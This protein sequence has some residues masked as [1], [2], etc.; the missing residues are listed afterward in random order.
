MQSSSPSSFPPAKN[1]KANAS[2]PNYKARTKKLTKRK[3]SSSSNASSRRLNQALVAC[4]DAPSVFSILQ[5]TSGALTLPAGGGALNTVNFSTALHRLARHSVFFST[6]QDWQQQQQAVRAS[7]LSDPRF[8]LFLASLAE[9]LAVSFEASLD[10]NDSNTK[11]ATKPPLPATKLNLNFKSRELSN[12][13]W[14]L[15]KL[16]IVPPVKAMAIQLDS[17]NNVSNGEETAVV[18]LRENAKRVRASVMEVA[19]QRH[20]GND[21]E[22]SSSSAQLWIPALSQ[23]AGHIM[24]TI[25]NIIA[26]EY[27][28]DNGS[29]SDDSRGERKNQKFSPYQFQQQEWSNLLWA[30]GTS[31]RAAPEVFAIIATQ[32]IQK[33]K[34]LILQAEKERQTSNNNNNLGQILRPQEWSNSIYAFARVQV[35]QGHEELMSYIAHLLDHYPEF[36]KAYKTQELSNTAWGVATLL[37]N[38]KGKAGNSAVITPTETSTAL[39]ILRQM[40][41]ELVERAAEFKPQELANTIW[42]LATTGFGISSSSLPAS[43]VAAGNNNNY[44]ILSSDQPVQDNEL[45]LQVIDACATAALPRLA[46]FKSQELNNMAWA[47]ARLFSDDRNDVCNTDPAVQQLLYGIGRQLCHPKR[48]VAAQDIGTALWS[49]ATVGFPDYDVYR[50]VAS[51]LSREFRIAKFY[52]PQELSNTVWS[53]ATVEMPLTDDQKN[54]FDTTIVPEKEQSTNYQVRVDKDPVLA[55]LDIAA[56]ELMRR[57]YEFKA[58]EIKDVLW[59]FSKLQVRHPQLFKAVAEHLVGDNEKNG[60]GRGMAEFSSQG[61]GNLAWAFARQAQLGD[62]V[63]QRFNKSGKSSRLANSNLNGRLAV[64]TSSYFDYG[65]VLMQR[66]FQAIGDAGLS[67][68]ENLSKCK[69]QDIA[70][71]AWSFAVLGLNHVAFVE[72]VQSELMKRMQQALQQNDY[73]PKTTFKG[74]EFANLFWTLATLN[75]PIEEDFMACVDKYVQRV[76]LGAEP[77]QVLRP[78]DIALVLKRQELANIAWSCAVLGYYPPVLMQTLYI[79]LLGGMNEEHS[80]D[81]VAM[82]NIYGDAGLQPQAIMTLIYVQASMDRASA[83]NGLALPI[84]FPDNWKQQEQQ[85]SKS[86]SPRRNNRND[87]TMTTDTFELNLSTSKIQQNVANAF[88]RIDFNLVEEHVITL[89]DMHDEYDINVPSS[90]MQVLSIDIANTEHKIAIEVDGPAHFIC[91]IDDGGPGNF[92]HEASGGYQKLTSGKLEYQFRWTGKNQDINGATALKQHL[93]SALGWRLI[94]LPFWE[95]YTLGG[96]PAKEEDYCRKKLENI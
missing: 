42:A 29:N 25:S 90:E 24:D 57:P 4:E 78:R 35:Y 89:K 31:D 73:S 58:Q 40:S 82:L 92:V 44:L 76:I 54:V 49:F 30:W 28:G 86:L 36:V 2:R 6:A 33:Q 52:K 38:K 70:N 9:A 81:P 66:L 3:Q 56:T 67:V 71:T 83:S 64:Y 18:R 22:A 11:Q 32:M 5:Q 80:G 8:A 46:R 15:A 19:K 51:R 20:E 79:G 96:D 87:Q 41:R 10:T 37:S 23:L 45:M 91:R 39:R 50:S 75:T 94:H 1:D 63:A 13:G 47:L 16:K 95:W 77:E 26:I 72:T 43:S 88:R 85:H 34:T 14:A 17:D 69:P 48:V 74:Q 65:E 61:L 93:L 55:A 21:S 7:I 68:Q 62:E 59:S 27:G 84:N 60:N 12:I 53:F